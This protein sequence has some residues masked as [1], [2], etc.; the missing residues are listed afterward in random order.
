MRA[1]Y[2]ALVV[3]HL[4]AAVVWLGALASFVL[5]VA[6]VLRRRLDA[7]A[8]A[9]LFAAFGRRLRVVGWVALGSAIASGVALVALRGWWGPLVRGDPAFW[10]SPYG[11]ALAWKLGAVAATLVVA[12]VHDRLAVRS[13]QGSGLDRWMGRLLALLGLLILL[14]AVQLVR[15]GTP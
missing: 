11:H 3:V 5:V 15:S 10:R 9:D 4:L 12:I 14:A 13:R 8:R 2:L 6:P 1:G 7:A